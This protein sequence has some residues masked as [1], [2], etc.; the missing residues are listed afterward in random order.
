MEKMCLVSLRDNGPLLLLQHHSKWS[1][2]WMFRFMFRC[3]CM[4]TDTQ[5]ICTTI[6]QFSHICLFYTIQFL[7][8]KENLCDPKLLNGSIQFIHTHTIVDVYKSI[9]CPFYKFNKTTLPG[10]Q[11]TTETCTRSINVIQTSQFLKR[12]PWGT[13]TNSHTSHCT[14]QM[15]CSKHSLLS[16]WTH[17]LLM[18]SVWIF[19]LLLREHLSACLFGNGGDDKVASPTL[20]AGVCSFP[21]AL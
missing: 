6:R 19:L 21:K 16:V 18:T 1:N 3:P 7:K 17:C 8:K 2:T 20:L 9:T 4:H 10:W 14:R 5:P 12:F 11:I 13:D 15:N